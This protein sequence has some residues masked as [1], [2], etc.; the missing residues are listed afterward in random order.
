MNNVTQLFA[1]SKLITTLQ[2]TVMARGMQEKKNTILIYIINDIVQEAVENHFQ[3]VYFE[4]T[5]IWSNMCAV[6]Q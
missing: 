3:C 4:N 6:V 2:S 1:M 5:W